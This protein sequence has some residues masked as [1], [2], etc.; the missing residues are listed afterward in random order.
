MK[1]ILL[2]DINHQMK[3]INDPILV[4]SITLLLRILTFIAPTHV[5]SVNFIEGLF[6]VDM[7][8]V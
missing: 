4:I 7:I 1:I 5:S 3:E 2:S 6:T 8:A